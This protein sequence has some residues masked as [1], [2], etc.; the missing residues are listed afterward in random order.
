M[1]GVTSVFTSKMSDEDE[2]L[3]LSA[4]ASAATIALAA[5]SVKRR[6][7]RAK[8]FWMRPLFQRRHERGAYNT[9][10]AELRHMDIGGD[11]TYSGFTRLNPEG[12]DFLLSLVNEDITGQPGKQR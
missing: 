9:L 1:S 2:L 6:R 11:A 4:A 3:L 7:K 12:F 5:C 10:M 8:R